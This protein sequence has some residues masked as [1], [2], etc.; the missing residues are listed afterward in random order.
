MQLHW[1]LSRVV[2]SCRVDL[3]SL[4]GFRWDNSIRTVSCLFKLP[5][6]HPFAR[7][8]Q[9][10]RS[11]NVAITDGSVTEPIKTEHHAEI[12]FHSELFDG[13]LNCF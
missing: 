1:A 5:R 13:E 10:T 4:L 7:E 8:V 9:A 3:I 11:S 6:G 12:I 2:Q